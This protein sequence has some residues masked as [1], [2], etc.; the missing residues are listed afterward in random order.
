MK[1]IDLLKDRFES[2]ITTNEPSKSMARVPIGMLLIGR[3]TGFYVPE[4]VL[5]TRIIIGCLSK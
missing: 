4:Y 2:P 1:K 5:R 3:G